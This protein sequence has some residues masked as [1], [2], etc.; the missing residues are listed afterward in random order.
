MEMVSRLSREV[1][2]TGDLFQGHP[3]QPQLGQQLIPGQ[4]QAP[5]VQGLSLFLVQK[6]V[7]AHQVLLLGRQNKE[8]I[9]MSIGT[10]GSFTQ[11]RLAIYAAQTG[12]T[13][14]GH[15]GFRSCESP[16]SR[17]GWWSGSR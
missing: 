17:S 6:I 15:R 5:E 3:L 1:R 13:V 8:Y 7:Q 12:I 14:T 9:D 10:F 11:A 16:R 4:L 2:T